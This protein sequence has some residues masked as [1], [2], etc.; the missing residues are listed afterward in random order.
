MGNLKAHYVCQECGHHSA[1]WLGKCPA[2]GS[3][4]TLVE[5]LDQTEAPEKRRGGVSEDRLNKISEGKRARPGLK[6]TKPQ[7]IKDLDSQAETRWNTGIGELDR[8]LGGGV[9]E[10]SFI[11]LG[12]DP[13]IGK[14]TLLLQALEK[15]AQTKKVLYVTGEESVEQVKL[16]AERLSVQGDDLFLAS[17]TNFEK[18]LS[19]VEET[20]PDIL[21]IDS[22]QTMFTSEISSAPGSVAQVREVGARLM[23]IAKKAGVVVIMIGHVT[24]DGTIAG[25]RVL[26][27][28]VDTVLQFESVGGQTFRILR[29]IKNR[30][31]STNE[32]GVFDMGEE[33][34][35]EVGNPSELFLAERPKGAPGSVVVSSMEGSRP[36]LVELQ[37]LVSRSVLGNPRRTVLGVDLARASIL[38]AVLEKRIGLE[39]YDKDVY[40]NVVGGFTLS[41]PSADLGMV[42]AIASS[43]HNIAIPADT[44]FIGEIGL[45]GE[46][47]SVTRVE[48]RLREAAMMGFKRCYL[49]ERNAKTL[50]DKSRGIELIPIK[51]VREL[52]DLL[53]KNER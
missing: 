9:V 25:P 22:I 13:G 15:M 36:L 26:E 32:I 16:R 10:G 37:A 24:K 33:G 23:H 48:D 20:G 42:A 41:E 17:E 35:K 12:G 28:M 18:I 53:F 50:K 21:A 11:L 2:C 6:S 8:V 7:R 49:P 51:Q 38:L 1:Q 4:N 3:W 34:M 46:V 5:E 19:M 30:F 31:G 47:R 27:H 45:T 43:F 52:T 39:L 14:S 29:A 44:M 40:V